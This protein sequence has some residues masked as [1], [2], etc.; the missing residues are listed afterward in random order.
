MARKSRKNLQTENIRSQSEI[1]YSTAVYARLSMED[2]GIQGDSIE[3][4][5]EVIEQYISKC[6]DLNVVRIFVE[7]GETGTNF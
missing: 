6:Q 2:N 3:N 1:L 4:Q 7:N 5:I